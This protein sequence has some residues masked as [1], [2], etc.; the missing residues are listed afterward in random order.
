MPTVS[1]VTHL[2]GAER[3]V[4]G[5]DSQDYRVDIDD[6]RSVVVYVTTDG[7]APSEDFIEEMFFEELAKAWIPLKDAHERLRVPGGFCLG[8]VR[9]RC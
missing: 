7:T 2:T 8:H 1:R 3:P 5:R 9:P 6:E 4:A